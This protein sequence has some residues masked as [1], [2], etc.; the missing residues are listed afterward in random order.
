MPP[1][2]FRERVGVRVEDRM[3]TKPSYLKNI[4]TAASYA[5][6]GGLGKAA[7][8]SSHGGNQS[9]LEFKYACDDLRPSTIFKKSSSV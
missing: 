2:P 9:T 1:L 3:S 7:R 4:S 6:N 5:A 8:K